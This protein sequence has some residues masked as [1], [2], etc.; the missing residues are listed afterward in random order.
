MQLHQIV[1]YFIFTKQEKI[2]DA[3]TIAE[4]LNKK[5]ET[6]MTDCPSRTGMDKMKTFGV[7]QMG[8]VAR[9]IMHK[10]TEDPVLKER[11]VTGTTCIS[12][13]LW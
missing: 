4:I 12:S 13:M 5:H 1:G 8:T 10:N 2:L 3:K 7:L 11:S 6:A 9:L